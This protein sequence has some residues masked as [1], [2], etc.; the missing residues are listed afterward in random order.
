VIVA[1]VAGSGDRRRAAGIFDGAE[2]EEVE[3]TV[4][5]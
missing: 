3:A 2:I 1:T 5:V 4:R